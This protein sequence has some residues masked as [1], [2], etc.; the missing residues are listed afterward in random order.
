VLALAARSKGGD[1]FDD[2]VTGGLPERGLG[3]Q[4]EGSASGEERDSLRS[5][6][7]TREGR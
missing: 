3:I 4:V 6:R 2:E 7:L 1:L 5:S